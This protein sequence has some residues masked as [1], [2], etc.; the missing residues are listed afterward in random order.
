MAVIAAVDAVDV[1]A[2][3]VVVR[4]RDRTV[5]AILDCNLNVVTLRS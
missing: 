5:P 3:H 1:P 4:A 2:A